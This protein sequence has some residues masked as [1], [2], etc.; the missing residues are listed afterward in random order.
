M[1]PLFIACKIAGFIVDDGRVVA[2]SARA[3]SPQKAFQ[4]S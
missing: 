1:A 2:V 3:V 4:K